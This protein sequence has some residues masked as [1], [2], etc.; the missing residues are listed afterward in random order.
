MDELGGSVEKIVYRDEQS[1]FTV[2][3]ILSSQK[4]Q[5]VTVIGALASLQVGEK[6]HC[7]GKWQLNANY[8]MQLRVEEWSVERP[9]EAGAIQQFL[10]SGL[11]KGVGPVYAQ[12]IVE[13]FG[14]Q[15]LEVIDTAPHRLLE[16]EGIGEKKLEGIVQGWQQHRTIRE[17][18]VFL[19]QFEV[20]PA[21]AQ[22]LF[23]MYGQEAIEKLRANP[24][25]LA[26]DVQG[27]GFKTADKL[28]LKMGVAADAPERLDAAVEYA[29]GEA[30]DKGHVCYPREQFVEMAAHLVQVDPEQVGSRL[31]QLHN[32]GRIVIGQLEGQPGDW[33]WLK[34]LYLAERGVGRELVRLRQAPPLPLEI[35]PEVLDQVQELLHLKLAPEQLDAIQLACR[36]PLAIVTGGPGTGKST[37]TRALLAVARSHISPICLA[38]PTGR[39][40][41]RLSQVTGMYASTLHS[42]LEFDPKGR[43]FKRDKANPLNCRLLIVD[44]ASM[45]DTTL[46]Y[47]LLKAVPS[48]CRLLLI[49]DVDQLPSVGPGCVLRDLISWGGLPVVRLSHIY[50]QGKG[51]RIIA[52][53]HRINQGLYP[54]VETQ[55]HSDFFFIEANETGEVAQLLVDLVADRLPK[56]YGLDP[57]QHIQVLAPMRRGPI[58]IEALN[59]LFQERLNPRPDTQAITCF[60]RRLACGDKVMQLRNNYDKEVFNG[61]VGRLEA[62]DPEAEEVTVSFE[63]RLVTYGWSELD[64]LV[65][66]YAVSVHK[67]QGSE[68]PCIVMPVHTS[69]YQLL[70][71]NLLYTAVTRG[72]KLVVL[73]GSTKALGI[74]VDRQEASRRFTGLISA[75]S[76]AD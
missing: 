47:H 26:R 37:L 12:K 32:E 66:A 1:G 29:L 40:A 27:V 17:L 33:V 28:A 24:Y 69:H 36:E 55:R 2:A 46:M 25:R 52:N 43:N 34:G 48:G 9:A 73:V 8:G 72:K 13:R 22:K 10:Q 50:R 35:G 54:S 3:S 15:A 76:Q 5:P 20:S 38:A 60:G 61:D 16:V 31:E 41:K 75:C 4:Q 45:I 6:I 58:G 23:K 62:I 63:E 14:A 67:Y 39:A 44:E 53:A 11:I 57:M 68:A 21:F 42:L 18:I 19:Q 30:S 7:K 65:L 64:E 49:G 56:A 71:R 59:V 74:A 51:S 70:Y